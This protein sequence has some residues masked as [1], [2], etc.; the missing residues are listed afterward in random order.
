ML[1]D[2]EGAFGKIGTNGIG[3]LDEHADKVCPGSWCVLSVLG[4]VYAV[5]MYLSPS[6]LLLSRSYHLR[7]CEFRF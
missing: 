2:L 7:L 4:S 1:A 3:G 6:V 5:G